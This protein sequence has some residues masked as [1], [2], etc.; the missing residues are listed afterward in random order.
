MKRSIIVIGGGASGLMAAITAAREGAHVTLLE[1]MEKPGKKLLMT[2]NGRCNLT[3]LDF[4]RADCYRSSE[5]SF[6]Q[7]VL[8]QFDYQQTM[9]FFE[10]IGLFLQERNGGIYPL[11]DQA[12]SVVDRLILE[13]QKLPIKLKCREKVRNIQRTQNLWQVFTETWHYEGDAVIL[14]TGSKAVPITGSD[15][16]GYELAKAAGHTVQT[17][18]PALVPLKCRESFVKKLAG[19]RSRSVVTMTIVSK[20]QKTKACYSEAGELQWTEYGISGI[21]V[22]Q[23]SRYASYALQQGDQVKISIDCLPSVSEDQLLSRLSSH[24]EE[25]LSDALVGILPKKMIPVILDLCQS[26]NLSAKSDPAKLKEICHTIKHLHLT[27]TG[28]RSFDQ[29]QVCAGGVSV[30]EINPDTMESRICPGLYFTGELIDVDGICGGY[31]L[32]WAWATGYLAGKSSARKE[33]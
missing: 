18:F 7:Q 33:K 19:L 28:T 31:N 30:S 23:L 5:N 1:A 29:A 21:V 17:P 6:W 11:T 10:E 16:S 20:D 27:V 4:S 3:N 15:G 8:P 9:A 14:A 12:A 13:I 26:K 2:G 24:T 25:S 32:Q 22:F